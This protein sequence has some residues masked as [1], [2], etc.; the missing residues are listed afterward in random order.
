MWLE[1][2]N[3]KT[4]TSQTSLLLSTQLLS[5]FLILSILL[6]YNTVLV[7]AIA[8]STTI[9]STKSGNEEVFINTCC[10]YQSLFK[11]TDLSCSTIGNN[12]KEPFGPFFKLPK[13]L[14]TYVFEENAEADD[15]KFK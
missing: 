15:V 9:A 12:T 1:N 8:E 5:Y 10:D 3:K 7:Q 2:R 13:E 11:E 14:L 4:T 6:A